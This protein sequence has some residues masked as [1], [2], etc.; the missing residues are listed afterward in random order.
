MRRGRVNSVR[1]VGDRDARAWVED[2]ASE[3]I[4]LYSTAI[5]SAIASTHSSWR[6]SALLRSGMTLEGAATG[7]E[8][9]R[10]IDSP[11]T[12]RGCRHRPELG[13]SASVCNRREICS[14]GRQVARIR[15]LALWMNQAVGCPYLNGFGNPGDPPDT[16]GAGFEPSRT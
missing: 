9:L 4:I 6:V 1:V 15:R 10:D 3:M 5:A 16:G 11:R 8:H 14:S 7:E 13:R 2:E 12:A